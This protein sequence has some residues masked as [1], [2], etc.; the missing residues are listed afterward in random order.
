MIKELMDLSAAKL[1]RLAAAKEQM[2]KLHDMMQNIIQ[3]SS[4]WPIKQAIQARRTMAA[5]ARKKIAEAA[6][7]RW[8]KVRAKKSK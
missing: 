5:A 3:E 8:A 7:T 2:E 1:R 6:R 4:P